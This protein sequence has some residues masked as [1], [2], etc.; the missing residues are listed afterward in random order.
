MFYDDDIHLELR[1]NFDKI[2]LVVVLEILKYTSKSVWYNIKFSLM[3]MNNNGR[4]I[5]VVRGCNAI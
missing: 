3:M 5:T 4:S 1:D 2:E